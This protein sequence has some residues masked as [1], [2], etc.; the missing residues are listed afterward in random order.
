M[1]HLSF[2]VL[3]LALTACGGDD[4]KST[5]VGA[6]T[7]PP[8]KA[9][10]GQGEG[11][12]CPTINGEFKPK[13]VDGN[14]GN[15]KFTTQIDAGRFSYRLSDAMPMVKADGQPM[16]F[17]GENGEAGGSMLATCDAN[18][19]TFMAQEDGKKPITIKYTPVD[20]GLRGDIKLEDDTEASVDYVRK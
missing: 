8:L 10:A 14:E 16:R 13:N 18:S 11:V 7:I 9:I 15:I 12:V 17:N 4:K 5:G 6:A 20:A 19:V 1:K 3:C 2:V